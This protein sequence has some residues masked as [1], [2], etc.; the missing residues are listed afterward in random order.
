M[1]QAMIFMRTKVDADNLEQYF[2]SLDGE[3]KGKKR[4]MLETYFSCVVLHGDRSGSERKENLRRFKEG[5]VKFLICTD[6]AAR[7]IDVRE[8]PYMINFTLPDVPEDYIHRTGRVGRADK[9]GLAI[10]LVSA[11]K[12]KVWYHNCSSRG[13]DCK[14]TKLTTEGGCGLW[15]DEPLFWTEIQR[16]LG[17][18]SVPE[19]EAGNEYKFPISD[20]DKNVV[21]G[22]KKGAMIS[23]ETHTD[24]LRERVAELAK[25]EDIAQK[26][27][28]ALKRGDIKGLLGSV[29][30]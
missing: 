14:N 7:G 22:Q 13:K 17:D 12:E 26:N 29:R 4:A 1:E 15:W 24:E 5:E 16:R 27:F 21:Y 25:L 8:L 11:H 3:E 10:S 6:V 2:H 28:W 30:R 20:Y 9:M 18:L 19:L 23:G